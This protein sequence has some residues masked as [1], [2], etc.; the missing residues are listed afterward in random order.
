MGKL[1]E[2][3]R[4][5]RAAARESIGVRDGKPG[6]SHGDSNPDRP[7]GPPPVPE[8]MRGV[9][10][11]RGILT[12]PV[13]RIVPDPAQ[14][15]KDFDQEALA[16][17]AENLRRRGQLQPI[18][19]RWDARRSKYLI[20]AGERRWRAGIE[21]GLEALVCVVDDRDSAA[22]EVLSDQIAENCARADLAPLDLAS[23]VLALA[24]GHG[25]TTRK[26][27]EET[28][29]SQSAVTRALALAELPASVQE[30]VREGSLAP[31]TAVEIG[32]LEDR[33]H[34]EFLVKQVVDFRWSRET[35]IGRVRALNEAARNW[36]EA[37]RRDPGAPDA[38]GSESPDLS[39][40]D[41]PVAEPGGTEA[42]RPTSPAP[43]HRDTSPA[44]PTA[45]PVSHG[46]SPPA[47]RPY[48]IEEFC[49][50]V[51]SATVLV[52]GAVGGAACL[53][54]LEGALYQA[55]RRYGG[56]S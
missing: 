30:L 11:A 45:E 17:L 55:R 33:A 25:W 3:R 32:R 20:V 24:A 50:V 21:A 54:A 38:T 35:V 13:G 6:L 23:A 31:A 16:A 37:Q 39:H 46:D 51:K 43:S 27:A 56:G 48:E 2:L 5:G 40:R 36:A 18:R 8:R 34:I 42:N 52:E 49:F 19:V 26:I 15:R 14:P 10:K 12:I 47:R 4:V 28:G 41:S 1:D 9:A 22:E 44:L 53:K 7:G 29:L